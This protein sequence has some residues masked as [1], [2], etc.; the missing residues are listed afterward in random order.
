[1]KKWFSEKWEKIE[2]RYI[3]SAIGFIGVAI[4]LPFGIYIFRNKNNYSTL[5]SLGPVGDFLGGST[6]A[7]LI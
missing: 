7:F 6:I 5:D 4:L 1:M 3:F 2:N